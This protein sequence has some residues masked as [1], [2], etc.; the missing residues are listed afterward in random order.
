MLGIET[1]IAMFPGHVAGI[2][3]VVF[4]PG[5]GVL[6]GGQ[7]QL[8]DKDGQKGKHSPG[9]S[10]SGQGSVSGSQVPKTEYST[11]RQ[12]GKDR[13]DGR[14]TDLSRFGNCPHGLFQLDLKIG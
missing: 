14:S 5:N 12:R 8:Q 2:A 6:A 3:V 1:K 13:S 4:V 10:S 11:R 9:D 7:G